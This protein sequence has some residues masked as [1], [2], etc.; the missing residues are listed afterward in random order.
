MADRLFPVSVANRKQLELYY[1]KNIHEI[2][3]HLKVW[4]GY[5]LH[6]SQQCF[7]VGNGTSRKNFDLNELRYCSKERYKRRSFIVG[8]NY[9][10]K[11]FDVDLIV[12]QDTKVL[13][14][15]A[16]D[17][18][19]TPV[20]APLLKYNWLLDNNKKI[21]NF[22]AIRFPSFEMS[23]WKTG[24]LALYMGCL[25]GFR[26]VRYIAFDGG[27]ECVH[28]EVDGVSNIDLKKTQYR[29]QQLLDSFENIKINK[30]E[31]NLRKPSL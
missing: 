1:N 11:E 5:L 14:D 13:F 12:A 20:C 27:T 4:H 22:Y 24:E 26:V 9:I 6:P 19:K 21:E 28:R 2:T 7:V 3:D 10:Y 31:D 30:F 25:L 18:V 8:C 15:L 23:R 16:K 29:I 17:K